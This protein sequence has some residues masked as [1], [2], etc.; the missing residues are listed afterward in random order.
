[1]KGMF[2]GKKDSVEPAGAGAAIMLIEKTSKN[3]SLCK[4]MSLR[5]RIYGW[6]ICMCV[7]WVVSFI[8][9]GMVR[10]LATGGDIALIKFFVFYLIG[11]S[12]ALGS[13]FFLWGP[14][15][16]C[17]SMFDE[18]RRVVTSIYM[19]CIVSIITLITMRF[20]YSD[21]ETLRKLTVPLLFLLIF[22]QCIA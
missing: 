20:I 22:I 6:L 14:I 13:S 5:N 19:G 17:K 4:K 15:K 16:Q 9:G 18:T 12:C 8:S 1:M 7:G 21:N 11:T 3:E 2:G 10:K